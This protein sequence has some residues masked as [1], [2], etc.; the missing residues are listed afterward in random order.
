MGR[1]MY[2]DKFQPFINVYENNFSVISAMAHIDMDYV[3]ERLVYN[4][5]KDYLAHL[6]NL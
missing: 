2:I 3:S 4:L 6:K 1:L 5:S